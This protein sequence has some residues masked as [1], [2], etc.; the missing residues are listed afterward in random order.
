MMFFL[1]L[2]LLLYLVC[3]FLAAAAAVVV[4]LVASISDLRAMC[5]ALMGREVGWLS[6]WH[7]S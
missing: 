3:Y 7:C 2:L 1:L 5:V 4:A 6:F